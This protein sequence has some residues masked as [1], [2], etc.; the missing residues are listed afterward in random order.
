MFLLPALA[1]YEIGAIW[2]PPAED[3]RVAAWTLMHRF[4]ELFGA[5][6]LHLPALAVVA[7]FLLWHVSTGESWRVR[8]RTLLG[9]TAESTALAL[10]LLLLE[11]LMSGIVLSSSGAR[12]WVSA[13]VLSVGAGIYEELVFRLVLISLLALIL[14]DIFRLPM[15]GSLIFAVMIS[16]GLFAA[17]HYEPFGQDTYDTISF[18]FR[19]A[20]GIYLAGIFVVR[21]FGI[22]AGCHIIYDVAVATLNASAHGG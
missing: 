22:A 18:A 16:S 17:H 3:S 20:A 15:T 2:A 8:K 9:M 14:I 7:V 12:E 21:G 11:R 10:P 4:F 19:A 5:T 6:S 13:V 1:L